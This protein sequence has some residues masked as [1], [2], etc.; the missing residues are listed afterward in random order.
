MPACSLG[1]SFWGSPMKY[2]LPSPAL[3]TPPLAEVLGNSYAHLLLKE[4]VPVHGKVAEY[5]ACKAVPHQPPVSMLSSWGDSGVWGSQTH[6]FL[7]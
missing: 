1:A 2:A 7:P 6:R 4:T 5:R 3:L